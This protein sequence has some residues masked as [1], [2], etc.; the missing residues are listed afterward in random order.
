M[1]RSIIT[2]VLF[3]LI[4][5][6]IVL[7]DSSI[8]MEA[9]ITESIHVMF[10]FA[11]IEAQLYSEIKNQGFNV[12]TIPKAIEEVFDDQGLTSARVIYDWNQEVF[13]DDTHSIYVTLLLAGSDIVSYTLNKTDMTR[14]FHVRADWRRFEINFA[15]N[16]FNFTEH[17]GTPLIE[18][19]QVDYVNTN[20]K[21]HKAYEKRIEEDSAEMSFRFILPEKAF[22]IQ[23]EE[24]SI[25]FKI[26]PAFEDTILNSPFLIL[27]AI[28]IANIIFVVYRKAKK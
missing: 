12:S 21:V 18:W 28:I 2:Y 15:N 14:T 26:P 17:L 27:G 9:T 7:A 3:V 4:A 11:D 6:P 1:K 20:G 23:A 16:L 13:N 8:T 25:T 22:D 19:Q 24:D 5:T 10:S